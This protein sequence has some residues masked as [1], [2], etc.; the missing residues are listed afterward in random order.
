MEPAFRKNRL[1]KRE[2]GEASQGRDTVGVQDIGAELFTRVKE[3]A[4]LRG[5]D[6]KTSQHLSCATHAKMDSAP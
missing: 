2:C 6:I 1:Y 3:A 4:P 5:H